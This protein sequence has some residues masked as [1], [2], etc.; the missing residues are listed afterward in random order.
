MNPIRFAL[1][2]PVTILVAMIALAGS[3]ALAWWRMK[4]DIFPSLN[5]PVIYVA[6]PY[7]GMSPE[8]MEG[9]L[10]YYYEYHFLYIGNIHHVESRNIQNTSLMKLFFHPNT[11]MAQA[12]AETITQVNRARA[13][14]PEGTVPPFVMRYD[15][16]SVPVGY[17]VFSS[18]KPGRTLG[19]IQDQALN[20]VRPMFA[21]LPG[22]SA[23]PP[24]GAAARAITVD[25]KPHKLS[26]AGVTAGDVVKAVDANNAIVPAGSMR[27]GDQM[28]L[29]P[30]NA[31]VTNPQELKKILVK[32]GVYLGDVADVADAT[33]IAT[34]FALVNG[35][36]A[37]YIPVAKRAEASTLAV[38]QAV[39]DNLDKMR[40]AVDPDIKVTFEFDQ[41]PTV[42]R[43]I[44]SLE[45]EA[46]LGALL[47][48]LMVLLFLRD[49][50]S[51]IVVVLNIPLALVGAL[52]ALWLCDHTINLMTLGGLALAVGI[53][54]DEATVEVENI[55]SQME[56]G[57]PVARAVRL[58]NAETAVPRLLAMLCILA[59][60]IPS[61]F[62]QGAL[63]ALFVPLSLAVGF[64]MITSYLLSS[65]LVPVLSV[66]L[67]RNVHRAGSVS[68]GQRPP[69]AY[70]S[71]SE[72]PSRYQRLVRA[73][74]AV[75]W[76]FVP[77][78][79]AVAGGVIWLGWWQLGREIF[80]SVDAGQVQI[81]LHAPPGT[82]VEDTEKLTVQMLKEID[83]L[84][85]DKVQTSLGL[86]GLVPTSFPVNNVY[87]W[88]S[89]PEDSVMRI[90]LKPGSGLGVE[91]L[92]SRLRRELPDRLRAWLRT[93]YQGKKVPPEEI[94]ERLRG[95]SVTFEPGDIVNEIMS[96][97][98]P[99]PVEVAVSGQKFADTRAYAAKLRDRLEKIG[100]LT[101]LQYG[102]ALDYPTY[103][104]I[105]DRARVGQSGISGE[106]IGKT[107]TPTT[108]SSRFIVRN[109]WRDPESGIAYQVQ[110]QVPLKD[111]ASLEELKRT[112]IRPRERGTLVMV[113]GQRGDPAASAAGWRAPVYLGDVADFRKGKTVGE[114]DRYN[115]RRML[116]LTGNV[117][118]EDLGR[119]EGRVREV[120]AAMAKDDPP[121]RGVQVDV[122]GQL[123][124]MRQLFT[125]LGLGLVAAV[126]VILLLLWAYFQSLRLALVVLATVPAVVAGVALALLAT[127]TTLNLQSFM[128]AIMAIGVAVANSILLATFAERGRRGGQTAVEAAVDGA[129]LRLR[130]ILM[131]SCAMIAGML[132]LALGLGE[133]AEQT[134][135]LGRAVVGGLL[136]ATLTT[137]LVLPG[138]FALVMGRAPIRSASL[139]PDDPESPQFDGAQ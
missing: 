115:M 50:R 71:G 103:E 63:R 110:V 96:F 120:L 5:L 114:Y 10:T 131:T 48:G 33:D 84:T 95:L 29:V 93:E 13:F 94:E 119:L 113:D 82:R 117:E 79:F 20:R 1:R 12:M 111:M 37:I 22:V 51:V 59:V 31:M 8:Q 23:P 55:H 86:V 9:L 39:K 137:L 74:T 72:R 112:L 109:Y 4:V 24:F 65:T 134:S 2:H 42:S 45:H 139:D 92:R 60:F 18:E 98:A 41:S 101:D 70:A 77:V 126:V 130:P 132:P 46:L 136:A 6:Q 14:M 68:D 28:P 133:G 90:A 138:V 99:T 21:A 57:Y 54:V 80:P 83:D 66:W 35:R 135:P 36:E 32:P 61:F 64:S 26:S 122:R 97:G 11:D 25:V 123:D 129:R 81:R 19:Q 27:V 85:G 44:T 127:R 15:T 17:L 88:M 75:R 38:V 62:M 58:G 49:W 52:V 7:G 124:T 76:V 78:Y 106:D 89:G 121:P 3:G 47:T 100:T 91:E 53:L 67:L 128:G 73:L 40:E 30:F 34:S 16:G 108:S 107:L 43:S 69:V 118:G 125:G 102:Q 116:T 105:F 87:Q 56:H 104:V